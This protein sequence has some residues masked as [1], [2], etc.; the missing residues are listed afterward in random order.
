MKRVS[1]WRGPT[2]RRRAATASSGRATPSSSSPNS[3]PRG[4]VER[5][6]D[7]YF[8][9]VFLATPKGRKVL[10]EQEMSDDRRSVR[11]VTDGRFTAGI[12]LVMGGLCST[13]R[14][15]G[16]PVLEILWTDSIQRVVLLAEDSGIDVTVFGSGFCEFRWIADPEAPKEQRG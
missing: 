9:K 12:S 16:L 11:R 14:G 10:A 7:P 4:L 1:A 5:I 15:R 13:A 8:G 6:E 3:K 2:S